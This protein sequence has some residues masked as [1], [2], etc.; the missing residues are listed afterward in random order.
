MQRN[1][2]APSPGLSP[3]LPGPGQLE[4]PRPPA[5]RRGQLLEPQAA[6][7]GS[8]AGA[9]QLHTG[10]EGSERHGDAATMA[11]AHT[12]GSLSPGVSR[13]PSGSSLSGAQGWS[14]RLHADQVWS[15][16]PQ[17]QVHVTPSQDRAV[18]SSSSC[19]GGAMRA[20]YRRAPDSERGELAGGEGEGAGAHDSDVKGEGAAPSQAAPARGEEQTFWA[21]M[22]EVTFQVDDGGAAR[23]PEALAGSGPGPGGGLDGGSGGQGGGYSRE[24]WHGC[25]RA[26]EGLLQSATGTA[27]AHRDA[28]H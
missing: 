22:P 16:Q 23:G 19:S 12:V 21:W 26:W 2:L 11:A 4:S 18:R 6:A 24:P 27:S 7:S 28:G 1:P 25:G 14:P 3:R 15:P 10:S 8:P 9:L 5:G 17:P 20:L 13:K